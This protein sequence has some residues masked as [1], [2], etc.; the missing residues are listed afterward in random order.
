MTENFVTEKTFISATTYKAIQTIKSAK[1]RAILYDQLIYNGLTN[2]FGKTGIPMADIIL[3]MARPI[4]VKAVQEYNKKLEVGQ[5]GAEKNKISEEN[6]KKILDLRKNGWTL[7]QIATEIGC[8][9]KS[10]QRTITKEN[11]LEQQLDR[12]EDNRTCPTVGHTYEDDN[13]KDN[14]NDEDN[15]EDNDSEKDVDV[16][17]GIEQDKEMQSYEDWETADQRLLNKIM[18][19]DG[20]S[21]EEPPLPSKEEAEYYNGQ[22]NSEGPDTDNSSLDNPKTTATPTTFFPNGNTTQTTLAT[23]EAR[24]YT[25]N[26]M[27]NLLRL[28]NVDKKYTDDRE[29]TLRNMIANMYWQEGS[30]NLEIVERALVDIKANSTLFNYIEW[31]RDKSNYYDW[32]FD[33]LGFLRKKQVTTPGSKGYQRMI[34]LYNAE[35]QQLGPD[36]ADDGG[37]LPF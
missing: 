3:E 18:S 33:A 19:S 25:G 15:D 11:E 7:A 9:V 36:P 27:E 35:I 28:W 12:T 6:K 29:A 1:T 22:Q 4:Q 20:E 23:P 21:Y 16:D 5:K 37:E 2:T 10:V 13:E 17:E 24:L 26:L 32:L 34:N 31:T 14:D 8:S 30:E